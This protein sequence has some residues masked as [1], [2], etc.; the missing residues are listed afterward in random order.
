MEY[1]MEKAKLLFIKMQK[2]QEKFKSWLLSLPPEEILAHA[3]EYALREDILLVVED[4]EID[5]EQEEVLME[6]PM[7]LADICRAWM[8]RD[9]SDYMETLFDMV[10]NVANNPDLYLTTDATPAQAQAA[11]EFAKAIKE[12]ANNPENLENLESYLSYHF[13]TWL[14]K[15]GK[16]PEDLV[17]ELQHFATMN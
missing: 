1:Q 9:Q 13:Q 2:E 17:A 8:N 6:S 11:A 14:S 15:F 3:Y 4:N 5:A 7:P 10:E 12:L 16:T